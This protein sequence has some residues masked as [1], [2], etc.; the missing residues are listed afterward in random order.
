MG[1]E[2]GEFQKL[3]LDGINMELMR[4]QDLAVFPLFFLSSCL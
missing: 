2:E 3:G 4:S 1:Q